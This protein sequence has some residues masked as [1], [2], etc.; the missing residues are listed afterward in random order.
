MAYKV[1]SSAIQRADELGLKS[2]MLLDDNGKLRKDVNISLTFAGPNGPAAG[3]KITTDKG[4]FVLVDDD[5]NRRTASKQMEAGLNPI[6]HQG[7]RMGGLMPAGSATVDGKIQQV[8]ARPELRY[9]RNSDGKYEENIY[10]HPFLP[11]KDGKFEQAGLPYKT[12]LNEIYDKYLPQFEGAL[13]S[14]AQKKDR[15]LFT[16]YNYLQAGEDE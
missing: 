10:M 8:Y 6:Y 2:S 13:G 11:T 5:V 12:T 15:M 1:G 7:E 16:L 4:S 9:E 14:G 3:Y